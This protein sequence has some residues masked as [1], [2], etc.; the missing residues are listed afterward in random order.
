[1][2][3]E[4]FKRILLKFS[5]D[6]DQNS[7]ILMNFLN[8]FDQNYV[9]ELDDHRILILGFKDLNSGMEFFKNFYQN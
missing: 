2:T 6:F 7:V 9:Q 5:L 3:I 1:M 4:F 8:N